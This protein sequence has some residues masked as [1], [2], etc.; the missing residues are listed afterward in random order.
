MNASNEYMTACAIM[1]TLIIGCLVFYT[2]LG[3]S[4]VMIYGYVF[5]VVSG[6]QSY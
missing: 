6:S 2:I 5:I 1:Y 4:A 3:F